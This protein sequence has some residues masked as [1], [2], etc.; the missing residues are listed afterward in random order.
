[1]SIYIIFKDSEMKGFL[2][3]ERTARDAVSNLADI[4]TEELKN[5]EKVRVFREN[6]E[7]GVSIYTQILGNYING[8]VEL[9]HTIEYRSISKFTIKNAEL[10]S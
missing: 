10:D 4:L 1:M 2:Q 8:S 6:T 5:T 7:N 3:D 9:K